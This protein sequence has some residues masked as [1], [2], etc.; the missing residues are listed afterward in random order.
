MAAYGCC[1]LNLLWGSIPSPVDLAVAAAETLSFVRCAAELLSACCTTLATMY[2]NSQ[3]NTARSVVEPLTAL[4]DGE[5]GNLVAELP[6][7]VRSGPEFAACCS[8]TAQLLAATLQSQGHS[9]ACVRTVRRLAAGLIPDSGSAEAAES[10]ASG[11][12]SSMDTPRDPT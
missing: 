9:A 12:D 1:L 11:T 2:S 4:L 6:T 8:A 10:S 5:L 7:A 3:P